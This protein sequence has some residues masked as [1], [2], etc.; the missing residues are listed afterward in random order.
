MAALVDAHWRNRMLVQLDELQR[1]CGRLAELEHPPR[2]APVL[3]LRIAALR[4]S[5]QAALPEPARHRADTRVAE[6]A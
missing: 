2:V 4:A 1:L 3:H 5:F 6:P